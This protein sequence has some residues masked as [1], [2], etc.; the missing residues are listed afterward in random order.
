MPTS[1]PCQCHPCLALTHIPLPDDTSKDPQGC[2]PF[3]FNLWYSELSHSSYKQPS[4]IHRLWNPVPASSLTQKSSFLFLI[5]DILCCIVSLTLWGGHFYPTYALKHNTGY[6]PYTCLLHPDW[7]LTQHAQLPSAR[8]L[9]LKYSAPVPESGHPSVW[10][11]PH[12]AC[13]G[14]TVTSSHPS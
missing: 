7:A 9:S 12:H 13:L 5:S 4:H 11:T 14:W 3:S 8:K 1:F 6:H 10:I 2:S